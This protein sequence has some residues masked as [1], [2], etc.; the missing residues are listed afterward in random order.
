MSPMKAGFVIR[1][2]WFAGREC[3]RVGCRGRSKAAPAVPPHGHRRRR[4]GC[5]VRTAQQGR[6]TQAA[7]HQ[8]AGNTFGWPLF[9]ASWRPLDPYRNST[10]RS[11]STP[12]VISHCAKWTHCPLLVSGRFHDPG[13][14]TDQ[15]TSSTSVTGRRR[16]PASPS[17]QHP[18][19]IGRAP[20]PPRGHR[21]GRH[22]LR[23]AD[24]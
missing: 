13:G 17:G 14:R 15:I 3:P 21:H 5:T 20:T 6:R 12:R 1:C 24:L 9:E 10:E 16:F 22:S 23:P 7:F 2:I 4:I 19:W 18:R 11:L 8:D